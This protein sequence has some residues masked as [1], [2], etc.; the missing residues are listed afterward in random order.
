MKSPEEAFQAIIAS[1][2]NKIILKDEA[3]HQMGKSML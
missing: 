2:R 3:S 1:N